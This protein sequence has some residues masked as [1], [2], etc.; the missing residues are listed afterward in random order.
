MQ[1]IHS[2]SVNLVAETNDCQEEAAALSY[3]PKARA[4]LD[5]EPGRCQHGAKELCSGQLI[6]KQETQRVIEEADVLNCE[7]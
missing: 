5:A 7:H 1:H 3:Q 2:Q 6:Q 4:W